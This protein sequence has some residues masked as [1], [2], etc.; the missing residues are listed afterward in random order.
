VPRWRLIWTAAGPEERSV[1]LDPEAVENAFDG[2]GETGQFIGNEILAVKSAARL[3][4]ID[5]VT[6]VGGEVE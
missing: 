5:C 6:G 4:G 3:P 1:G 2:R